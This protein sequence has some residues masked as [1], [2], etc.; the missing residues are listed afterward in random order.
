M[1]KSDTN[2]KRLLAT[3]VDCSGDDLVKHLFGTGCWL[4]H[5]RHPHRFGIVDLGRPARHLQETTAAA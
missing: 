2:R 3:G 4:H 5:I 1:K